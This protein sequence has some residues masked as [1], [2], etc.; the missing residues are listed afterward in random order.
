MTDRL[1]IT[2]DRL[3]DIVS[4]EVRVGQ[5]LVVEDGRVVEVV[6]AAAAP[7]SMPASVI[8]LSGLT[9]VPGLIDCHSHLVGDV[10]EAGVPA[11]RP[12]CVR[13]A[14]PAETSFTRPKSTTFTK[15]DSPP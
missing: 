5:A 12:V 3:L 6:A 10:Q 13:F 9:V 1:V 2:T 14:P 7:P 4:G 15:S 8:D 11:T